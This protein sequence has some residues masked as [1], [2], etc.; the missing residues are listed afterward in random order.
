MLLVLVIITQT[1]PCSHE[2]LTNTS[3]AKVVVDSREITFTTDYPGHNVGSDIVD[4][5]GSRIGR[6]NSS[7]S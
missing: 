4:I 3:R 2:S 7:D 6:S 1:D 5:I